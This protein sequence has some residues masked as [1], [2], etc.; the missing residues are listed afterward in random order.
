[1]TDWR[2][3]GW[4]FA[5]LVGG[6]LLATTLPGIGHA[7]AGLAGGFVAGYLAENGLVG[8]AYHGLLAGAI[9]GVVVAVLFGVAVGLVA[10]V[11][12]GPLGPLAGGA[13]AL[14]GIV[15]AVVL[16]LDSA[17]AGAVGGLVS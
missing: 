6:G 2:A 4:G 3:V 15:V 7:A 9:G 10:T 5:V 8:G 14:A 12:L 16:A 11:G 1:M 17:V 13:A